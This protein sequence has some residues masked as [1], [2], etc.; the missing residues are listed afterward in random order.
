MKKY[1]LMALILMLG[2]MAW[3]QVN[4]E[5]TTYDLKKV[6]KVWGSHYERGYAQGYLLAN[7]IMEVWQDYYWVWV[8]YSDSAYY[9]SLVNYYYNHFLMDARMQDEALGI[10]MGMQASGQNT[11]LTALNRDLHMEDIL[12]MNS[13]VDMVSLR[14]TRD[15]HEELRLGCASLSSWGSAT[16]QD[17]F[18]EGGAVITRF[19]D[20]TPNSA[21]IS[22][23]LLVVHFP[24]EADEIAWANFTFPGFIGAITGISSQ[25]NFASLNMGNDHYASNPQFL[26]PILF[27][28]R[29]ALEFYDA[30]GNSI[31]NP[32]DIFTTIS[33]G[34]HL[35]G[36]IIHT[37]GKVV[38]EDYSRVIE[39]NY[40]GTLQRAYDQY[41]NL[42]LM[43]LAA[44]NH[45][46]TGGTSVCC[47]RYANIQDSLFTNP[48]ISAKRQWSVLS[49]AAGMDD[50]LSAVQYNQVTGSLLWANA[51]LSSPAWSEP[52]FTIQLSDL[53]LSPVSNQ[54]D[55]QNPIPVRISIYPNPL[56]VNM[57]LKV[58]SETPITGYAMY[59]LRGQKLLSGH[60]PYKQ[61]IALEINVRMPAGVYLLRVETKAGATTR[62]VLIIG[63]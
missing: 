21:L 48:H 55:V 50:N 1:I 28:L 27:D 20:W 38:G 3:A 46:R 31:Q 37:L 32:L 13:V 45:F 52:A 10:Y 5:L 44:T 53:F 34:S 59:N 43:N 47:S 62:K 17:P 30:D 33:N 49:G 7:E 23:P 22:H 36:T 58:K 8:C 41:G 14:E 56:A 57:P 24:S 29:R 16:A 6:L 63:S 51:T 60:V 61:D 40:S 4:G 2:L 26:S 42:P 15:G 12:L 54:D 9:T 19:L 35:S 11:F 25:G 18:L 39:T